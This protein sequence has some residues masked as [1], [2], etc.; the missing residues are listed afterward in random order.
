MGTDDL[1][2][3]RKARKL[4]SL[5][6]KG[7]GRRKPNERILVI[8][9]DEKSSRYYFESFC[10]DHGLERSVTIVTCPD[11]SAP[12]NIVDY[13]D[14]EKKYYKKIYCVF[15]KDRKM[16]AGNISNYKQALNKCEASKDKIIAINSVPNF[17]Y[18][19]LLHY[20][21]YL[22]PFEAQGKHTIGELA[23]MELKKYMNDYAKSAKDIY[24]K[25]KHLL[26]LAIKHAVRVEQEQRKVQS[27]NPSTK[28][29]WLVRDL[30]ELKSETSAT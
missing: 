19:L 29:H 7:F 20:V 9:E 1:F 11:G 21:L 3:K 17:E 16:T 23:E 24:V 27:D 12:R 22:K 6:R 4:A 2:H 13:A 18:W 5:Q 15:D 10:K 14:K 26:D 25:T 8:C 30:L 28:I